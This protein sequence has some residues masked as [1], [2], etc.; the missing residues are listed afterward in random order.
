MSVEIK[1][2]V[3]KFKS[4]SRLSSIPNIFN[5][6]HFIDLAVPPTVVED[7]LA[8]FSS[9]SPDASVVSAAKG[10]PNSPHS[11]MFP[12]GKDDGSAIPVALRKGVDL[13]EITEAT[14]K[15]EKDLKESVE[16]AVEKTAQKKAVED[17]KKSLEIPVESG[18]VNTSAQ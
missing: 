13:A 11:F 7:S 1:P 3:L 9:F 17:L 8:D 16:K 2:L 15:A 4:V 12:D 14:R 10:T 6:P 18:T 5:N